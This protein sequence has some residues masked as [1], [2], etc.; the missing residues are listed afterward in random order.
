MPLGS[1]SGKWERPFPFRNQPH[2]FAWG[3]KSPTRLVH[4]HAQARS[5]GHDF[6]FG[7]SDVFVWAQNFPADMIR[8]FMGGQASV[9]MEGIMS[10]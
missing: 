3:G 1:N 10:P 2:L 5:N 6:V 9:P 4:Y 8:S 7:P